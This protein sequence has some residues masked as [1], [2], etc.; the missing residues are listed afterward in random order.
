MGKTTTTTTTTVVTETTENAVHIICILDRSGSMGRLTTEV[1]GSF[2]NFLKEQKAEDG[3]AYLTLVLFDN[4]YEVVYD[5]IDLME[6]PDL[7]PEVYFARGMT[8]MYDAIGITINSCKDKDVMVLIQTDGYENASHEYGK[9]D[10][11]KLITAKEALGWDFIFL[12]AN[13]DTVAEGS[14]IGISSA[15]SVSFEANARGIDMA[16]SSMDS[17][18]KM[19]RNMKSAEWDNEDILSKS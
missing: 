12:G 6:V 10:I 3:K 5:R 2:N 19:Y 8:A 1:I 9:T 17:S 15:K 13:I 4:K 16:Y 14:N 18:T 7:T 11:K